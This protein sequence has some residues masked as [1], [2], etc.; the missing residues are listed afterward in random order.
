[1]RAS[2]LPY[3]VSSSARQEKEITSN[4]TEFITK[5]PFYSIPDNF[6][7]PSPDEMVS[8]LLPGRHLATKTMGV[9]I[10]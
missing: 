4:Y 7:F 3:T 1:M 2:S 8:L 10:L 5:K 9:K 6:L